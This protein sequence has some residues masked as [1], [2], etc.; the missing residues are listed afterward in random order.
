MVN[1][2]DYNTKADIWSLG[3]VIYEICSLERMFPV[4]DENDKPVGLLRMMDMIM[5][6]EIKD[7]PSLYSQDLRKLVKYPLNYSANY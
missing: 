5:H 4:K 3:C 7:I 1:S 2:Q 6:K